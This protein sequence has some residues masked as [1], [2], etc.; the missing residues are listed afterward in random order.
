[1]PPRGRKATAPTGAKSSATVKK[2]AT[3]ATAPKTSRAN[4][5]TKPTAAP[6]RS[7]ARASLEES[8]DENE[9]GVNGRAQGATRATGKSK[10]KRSSGTTADANLQEAIGAEEDERVNGNGS[11]ESNGSKRKREDEDD[12]DQDEEPEKAP[13]AKRAKRAPASQS[14][15]KQPAKAPR[16]KTTKAAKTAAPAKKPRAPRGKAKAEEVQ[17]DEVAEDEEPEE[18][19]PAKKSRA[20]KPAAKAV[21]AAAKPAKAA[22]AKPAARTRGLGA[23]G[24]AFNDIPSKPFDVFVFGEGSSGELG[25]GSKKHDGKKPID[26]KRPRI[27][28]NLKGVVDIACGGMHCIALT[29]EQAIFTWG[30]N[31]DR[32]LGR[33]TQWEGGTRDVDDE[34]DSDSDDDDTG[35]NP[36]ESTP[37]RVDLSVLPEGT[38]I[39]QV[40]ATDSASFILTDDGW[41]YGW[42]TFRGS[43]GIIGFSEGVRT[44]HTPIIIPGLKNISRLACGSNHVLALDLTGKVF[45][46]GSGGQFQLGRK[47]LSRLGGASAGLSPQP[48][49]KFSKK[50]RAVKV[51]AG[52]YHSFYID[53]SDQVWAWGLNNYAQTGLNDNTG[54]DDA[55]V[56]QPQIVKSLEDQK[57]SQIAGG[58]HHSVACTADGKLLTWGRVDGHQVGQPSSIYNEDNALF[59]GTGKP[60]ILLT[61]TLIDGIKTTYVAAGTDTSFA[62]DEAGKVYS[63]GFSAN[64]QTG[65]GTIDDIEVPTL[66]DNTAIRDRKIIWAGAGGQFSMVAAAANEDLPN[67][68]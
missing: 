68:H 59:D 19:P 30:V 67:G 58:E 6:K 62:I 51:G 18:A 56:L 64:Y 61:P 45:T 24:V 47:P 12:Q 35:V 42:G 31:D 33:D 57:V 66:I 5:V 40:A 37:G 50:H 29:N 54:E 7:S 11:G 14:Q 16:A 8:E 65:Q 22:P 34:S 36:N 25:L 1:M 49:G 17:D 10:A 53:E 3:K 13:P 48:C 38:K 39:A 4:K 44:Q 27:N 43:D 41:V 2:T 21:K 32:A 23:K 15:P 63:W 46:W 9:N 52:S 60:R 26:V 55:M 28:H 20:T